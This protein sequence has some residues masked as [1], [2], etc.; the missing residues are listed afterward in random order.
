MFA[1]SPFQFVFVG[2]SLRPVYALIALG[3]DC[4]RFWSRMGFSSMIQNLAQP[5]VIDMYRYFDT[6]FDSEGIQLTLKS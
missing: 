4:A 2:I 1:I 5:T 3:C 6:W